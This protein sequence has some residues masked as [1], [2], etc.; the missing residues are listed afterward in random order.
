MSDRLIL[1]L[2]RIFA[3]VVQI[4]PLETG[5]WIAR[6]L[7]FFVYLMN[8]RSR[9]A[10]ANLK[11]AFGTRFDS[12]ERKRITRKH[13][14]NLLQNAVEVFRFPKMNRGYM[15]HY[16]RFEHLERYHQAVKSGRGTILMTPHFG[17]WEL[18]QIYSALLGTPLHV[19]AREQKHGLLNDFLN[20]LRSSCGTVMIHTGGG[21]RELIRTLKEGGATGVLGDLSG[22][23]EGIVVRFF[24][25]KTTAPAGI[26]EI[27][28]RTNAQ[29][30]PIFSVRLNG[31]FHQVFV[32]E[33]FPFAETGNPDRDISETVQNYYRL[34]ESWIERYPEQWFW[35]YKRWKH[36]FTKKI[37]IL[38]DEKAGHRS[39][40]EAVQRQMEELRASLP[41]DYE[42]EF[43]SVDVKFKSS[44][45]RKLFFAAAFLFYPFAQ[46]RLHLLKFFLDSKSAE[47]LSESYADIIISAGASLAPLNLLLN[48]E[49][50]A[51]SIVIMKPPFPYA[52]RFFDLSIVPIHDAFSGHARKTIRTF[53][54]PNLVNDVLLE[55]SSR[56]LGK[57]CALDST[58]PKRISV[59]I[60]GDSKSYQFKHSEFEKW[61][62]ALKVFAEEQGFELLMTTSRRTSAPISDLVK[63]E[64]SNHPACKLLVIA[65]ESNIENVTYGMLALSDI[66]LVTEDSVSM[67]SEAVS[68]EKKVVVMK[69]GNGKL[70]EKHN[71]FHETLH[72]NH[73]VEVANAEGFLEC[74][75]HLN[76]N[77]AR[78]SNVLKQQSELLKEALRK[79][80]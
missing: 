53:I 61:L 60:G 79:L 64:F 22:G 51:K 69:L 40:S 32:G 74:I 48:R 62:H 47:T 9:L 28:K 34:L 20:E 2:L 45:H 56:E 14:S 65:N 6:R 72:S 17:N 23:R 19:L 52:A 43:Q 29:M 73:L 3:F 68:A 39:Q 4:I 46:G 55:R 7:S 71:R 30:L 75:G 50:F 5:L 57:K 13:I 41:N 36:C 76:Q 54:A 49:N 66:A 67:I 70:P 42:M 63:R 12:K 26:F 16:I 77:G 31:P 58:A 27:A 35:F 11:A 25:R 1:I 8:D 78:N 59:F 37:M 38:R 18:T 80:L 44:F 24:G 21:V 33:S 15:E 10:Y